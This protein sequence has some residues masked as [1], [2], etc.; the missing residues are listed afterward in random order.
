MR[1]SGLAGPDH[2]AASSPASS[3][4]AHPGCSA[5][6]PFSGSGA[7]PPGNAPHLPGHRQNQFVCFQDET[8]SE[9]QKGR[10]R[11]RI[12][13]KHHRRRHFCGYLKSAPGSTPVFWKSAENYLSVT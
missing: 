1:A 5:P 12:C 4:F 8:S 2:Q 3:A 10:L 6:D 13:K 11:Q 7:I 9:M